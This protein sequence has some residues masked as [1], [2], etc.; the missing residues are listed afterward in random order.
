MTM[1]REPL[2][3]STTSLTTVLMRNLLML[4]VKMAEIA[5]QKFVAME[6]RKL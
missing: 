4:G 6:Y 5:L 2:L 3:R 1:L